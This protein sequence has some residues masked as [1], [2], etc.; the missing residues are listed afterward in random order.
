MACRLSKTSTGSPAQIIILTVPLALSTTKQPAAPIIPAR[1]DQTGGSTTAYRRQSA[2]GP[3]IDPDRPGA[4]PWSTRDRPAVGDRSGI[5]PRSIRLDRDRPGID[6]QS[7]E[8]Q[9]STG[10]DPASTRGRSEINRGYPDLGSTRCRPAVGGRSGMHLSSI[11]D[12]PE[13]DPNS[14]EADSIRGRSGIDFRST[15]DPGLVLA[16]SGPT[17]VEPGVG[18]DLG[19]LRIARGRSG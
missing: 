8:D 1:R 5:D 10:C 6:P 13:A 9:A 14:P 17:V 3:A 18:G 4:E 12:R 19:S 11:R 15:V 2:R 16:R 7:P